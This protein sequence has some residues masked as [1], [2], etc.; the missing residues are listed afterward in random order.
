MKEYTIDAFNASN[1]NVLLGFDGRQVN[2]PLPIVDGRYPEGDALNNLLSAYVR[3]AR[4]EPSPPVV[5]NAEAIQRLV[6][7]TDFEVRRA[8]VTARNRLL[9]ATDWTQM[10]DA[11]LT[12]NLVLSWKNYRQAL[13]DIPRQTGFPSNVVWPVPPAQITGPAGIVL[14]GV[15]GVP[16][17]FLNSQGGPAHM[18][19]QR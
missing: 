15:R 3:N 18:K 10:N 17:Q 4:T 2:F 12:G 6:A 7:A 11:P 13:R 14:T 8:V 16:A 5:S 19:V 1:H 9:L